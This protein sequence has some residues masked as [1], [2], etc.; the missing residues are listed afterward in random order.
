M[1]NEAG[2]LK[3]LVVRPQPDCDATIARLAG[4]GV[5][6]IAAPIL[7]IRPVGGF[8]MP[9]KSR[10]LLFTSANAPRVLAGQ[11]EA[12]ALLAVPVY[13][14]GDRTAE[15]ART[16]GFLDIRSAGG[17]VGDLVHMVCD[18]IRPGDGAIVHVRGRDVAGDAAGELARRGYTVE[19]VVAY[20]AAAVGSL[21]PDA[22]SALADGGIDAVLFY[23]PRTAELFAELSNRAGIAKT[24]NRIVAIALSANVAEKARAAGFGHV[25]V[26][27]RPDE[28]ALLETLSRHVKPSRKD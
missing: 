13:A 19:T 1:P 16:A 22:V 24:L 12:S 6:A 11:A 20:E 28:A 2:R 9:G 14:V 10:A 26:A 17:D 25:S 3:V 5:D 18:E 27:G 21:P 7:E 4:L 15:A 23:S 8:T